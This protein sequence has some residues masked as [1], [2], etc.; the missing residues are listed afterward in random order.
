MHFATAK[1]RARSLVAFSLIAA[2]F[3]N[4]HGPLPD[5]QAQRSSG[6]SLAIGR[7]VI[8]GKDATPL[9]RFAHGTGFT[10]RRSD[11][12]DHPVDPMLG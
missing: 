11:I 4:G 10:P 6:S 2:V 1:G 9:R 7:V 12:A 8:Q 5:V 3:G